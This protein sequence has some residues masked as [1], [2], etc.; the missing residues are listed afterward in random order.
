[1]GTSVP[2]VEWVEPQ[3]NATAPTTFVPST[4]PTGYYSH[5]KAQAEEISRTQRCTNLGRREQSAVRIFVKYATVPLKLVASSL[6]TRRSVVYSDLDSQHSLAY[7]QK[8]ARWLSGG[9]AWL[10]GE[11][12]VSYYDKKYM[13]EIEGHV[14]RYTA[15][16]TVFE[17]RLPGK[18]VNAALASAL[19]NCKTLMGIDFCDGTP[20]CGTC[21]GACPCEQKKAVVHEQTVAVT[22]QKPACGTCNGKCPCKDESQPVVSEQNATV[23]EHKPVVSERKV[24]VV[25]HKPACGTCNG[26]CPCEAKKNI[27]VIEHKP[28]CGTC[29]G[30]CPCT[31][32]KII[33]PDAQLAGVKY[34]HVLARARQP[35]HF[36]MF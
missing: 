35:T 9:A 26:A 25:E 24:T 21:N 34:A 30:A 29:N 19:Q 28:A 20:A 27:T 14:E 6:R 13:H 22:E 17:K 10:E 33:L 1:M 5:L 12:I 36:M 7:L 15:D 11:T 23:A 31:K 16:G 8:F 3:V 4:V 32:P 18:K 2:S